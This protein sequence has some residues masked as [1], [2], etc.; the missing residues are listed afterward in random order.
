MLCVSYTAF[1]VCRN[2][3]CSSTEMVEQFVN[4]ALAP[5]LEVVEKEHRMYM[6]KSAHDSLGHRGIYS[7]AE[8]LK[9]RFWWPDI[10]QD[11][12]WYIKTCHLCQ[13]RQCTLLEVPL[14]E[15]HTPSIFQTIHV[16]TIHMAPASNG[17][18]Y[19]VH[20]G[21]IYPLG[22][23]REHSKMRTQS[24]LDGGYLRKLFVVGVV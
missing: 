22:P 20:G 23:K 24:L 13:E 8:L 19:I 21:I 4:Q 3:P 10:E 9:Q 15:T 2:E 17:Y 1:S 14:I 11:V 7:T 5:G 18:K 16:D 12:V 6:L